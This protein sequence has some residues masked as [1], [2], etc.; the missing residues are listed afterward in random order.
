MRIKVLSKPQIKTYTLALFIF[1]SFIYAPVFSDVPEDS[2]YADAVVWA[3][4]LKITDGFGDGTFRPDENLTR[5]QFA[6][7]LFR[8]AA[9]AGYDNMARAELSGFADADE[10]SDWAIDAVSYAVATGLIEGTSPTTLDP[11]V[12]ISRAQCA[13][14]ITRTALGLSA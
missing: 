10:I 14:I 3:G 7:L 4:L 1:C 6:V 5:E 9:I 13:A 8:F 2:W 11:R 12:H